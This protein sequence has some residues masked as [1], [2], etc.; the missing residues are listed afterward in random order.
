MRVP[1]IVTDYCLSICSANFNERVDKNASTRNP[2]S[3][4]ETGEYAIFEFDLGSTFN[5]A[6]MAALIAPRPF[7]VEH[8]HF[9]GVSDDWTTAYE[10]AKVRYLYAAKLSL[11][12]RTEMERFVGLHTINGNGTFDLH[13]SRRALRRC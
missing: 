11:A 4:A 1:A 10:Y 6:E 9:D 8:G 13:L 7:M 5:Y 3:Y 12:E 2:R